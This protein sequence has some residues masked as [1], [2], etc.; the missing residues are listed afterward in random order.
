MSDELV[1]GAAPAGWTRPGPGASPVLKVLVIGGLIVAM[2]VPLFL[3]MQVI[4]ERAGRYQEVVAE[5]GR[6]WGGAQLVSGPILAVPYREFYSD[7]DGRRQSAEQTAFFLPD[8][9]DVT[10][11]V[12]PETRYR[13]MFQ[14][15]V[16][17]VDLHSEGSFT[18]PGADFWAGRDVQ[19][20]WDEAALM[21]GI[22]DQRS[23]RQ[24]VT[25]DWGG[26]TLDMTPGVHPALS[27]L[28]A[29][30]MAYAPAGG[31]GGGMQA[32]I[33]GLQEAPA[34]E[35]IPFA[36]DLTLNGSDSL[37]FVPLGEES[38]VAVA[39]PWPDPSFIGNYLPDGSTIGED[40]FS[41][42]WT[43]SY[44]GRSY[45]Q[46]WTTAED[47]GNTPYAIAQSAFGVRFFQPV[48]AYQQTERTAKYGILFIAFTFAVLFLFEVASGRRIHIFQYGLVGLSLCVFYLLLLAFAEVMGFG[49]AYLI[50]AA[51]V[52][53]QILLYALKVL[54]GWRR[55]LLLGA[56]LAGLYGGLYVLMQMEDRALMVGAVALFLLLGAVMYF[57]RNVD[58]YGMQRRGPA[59]P[60]AAPP[61]TPAEV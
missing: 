19:I 13:G 47:G 24:G 55:T 7:A 26:R 37:A 58:W 36:F 50:G 4:A 12:A 51:A 38:H 25:I 28:A 35:P 59:V 8:R 48:G 56:L 32:R 31:N 27:G 15:V 14:A 40:G 18:P 1:G 46:Q 16:Y 39:S 53:G 30:G 3:V 5:I 6:Q 57:T 33:A 22:S 9:Y 52:V 2:L 54:G 23:I 10:A 17:T 60:T 49:L 11:Q 61:A 44:F 21:V 20:R 34:G 45:P 42:E 43:L 41:A 29:T